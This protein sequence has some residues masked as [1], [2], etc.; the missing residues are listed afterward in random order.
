MGRS[1][2]I[3]GKIGKCIGVLGDFFF[4]RAAPTTPFPYPKSGELSYEFPVKIRPKRG[5]RGRR[6]KIQRRRRRG[7]YRRNSGKHIPIPADSSSS[8]RGGGKKFYG[9][10]MG[11]NAPGQQH[12]CFPDT[13]TSSKIDRKIS[14]NVKSFESRLTIF[15]SY[16]FIQRARTRARSF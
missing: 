4:F 6:P 15:L 13:K 3:L 14:K 1:R 7:D 2:C 8:D 16:S 9:K 11:V 10:G 12:P 5:R